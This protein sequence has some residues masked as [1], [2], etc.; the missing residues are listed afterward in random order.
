MKKIISIISLILISFCSNGQFLTDTVIV[1]GSTSSNSV[2]NVDL[3]QDGLKDLVVLA[4][5]HGIIYFYKNI[6]NSQFADKIAIVDFGRWF[7]G[8][9]LNFEDFDQD[10]DL[11]FCYYNISAS[12][13]FVFYRND[14]G[15]NF[16]NL[17]MALGSGFYP[18]SQNQTIAFKDL[19][20]DGLKDLILPGN[21]YAIYYR[22]LGNFQFQAVSGVTS[23]CDRVNIADFNNDGNK[24]VITSGSGYFKINLNDGS[25]VFSLSNEVMYGVSNGSSSYTDFAVYDY[26]QDGDNDVV[27]LNNGTVNTVKLYVNNGSGGFSAPS[28][29]YTTSSTI[30]RLFATNIDGDNI[31]DLV[32]LSHAA[33]ANCTVYFKSSSG[34]TFQNSGLTFHYLD[35]LLFDILDVNGDNLSELFSVRTNT[36]DYLQE[37]VT[38]SYSAPSNF[39][40][41]NVIDDFY[42]NANPDFLQIGDLNEDGLD[43]ILGFPVARIY[44]NTGDM[45]PVISYLSSQFANEYKL[46][47]LNQDGA[48]DIVGNQTNGLVYRLNNGSGTF[49]STVL[50]SSTDLS[51][52]G[53]RKFDIKDGDGDGDMD[54]YCTSEYSDLQVTRFTNNGNMNFV[55]SGNEYSEWST[56]L[57]L[58]IANNMI[59]S[60]DSSSSSN[61]I[62]V[63]VVSDNAS[64]ITC[65]FFGSPTAKL[66]FSNGISNSLSEIQ[67]M[68]I[69][70]DGLNDV[71]FVM[72][73]LLVW[74]RNQGDFTFAPPNA[75]NTNGNV[76]KMLILDTDNDGDLDIAVA[77]NSCNASRIGVIENLSFGN[78]ANEN[79]ILNNICFAGTIKLMAGDYQGDGDKDLFIHESNSDKISVLR[80]L[81]NNTSEISGTIFMDLDQNQ[82][83]DNND[84]G[85]S[86]IQVNSIGSGSIYANTNAIGDFN[87]NVFTGNH[88]ISPEINTNWSLTT[89]SSI[90]HVN[91][92]T[93]G[94]Q[95]DSLNFGIFPT[96]FFDSALVNLTGGF[97]R[98]NS[99]VNH[100]INTKNVGTNLQSGI[101]SLKMDT[102]TTFVYSSPIPD[103]IINSYCYWHY[104]NLNLN[105]FNRINIQLQFPPYTSMGNNITSIATSYIF[106]QS[107]IITDSITDTLS[108]VLVCGYDP[109]D[110]VNF[111]VGI[112]D[113]GFI[114]ND[115]EWL[116]YTIRFQNTGNDTVFNVRIVDQISPNLDISTFEL[117]GASSTVSI[118]YL[119]TSKLEFNFNNILLPDSSINFMGSQGFVV[120]KIKKN[121]N[122]SHGSEIKNKASIFFDMNPP[123]ITNT[124][125]NTIYECPFNYTVSDIDNIC[126]HSNIQANV[127]EYSYL[128]NY[129]WYLDSVELENAAILNWMSDT[130]GMFNLTLSVLNPLCPQYDT[131]FPVFIYPT[132]N[133]V[134]DTIS[135]CQGDS[136][137][138]NGNY[139]N[140]PN[141]YWEYLSTISGCDSIIGI[142]L[143]VNI[144]LSTILDNY[145]FDTICLQSN[146]IE[147]PIGYPPGGSY[148]GTG[149]VGNEFIPSIAGIGTFVTYYQF[150]DSNNCFTQDS[151]IITVENCL[152]LFEMNLSNY[153]IFPNPSNG[154]ISIKHNENSSYSL[155]ILDLLGQDYIEEFSIDQNIYEIDLSSFSK[156]IYYFEILDDVTNGKILYKIVLE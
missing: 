128:D 83:L 117:L 53:M 24:D 155:R 103:S 116:K 94:Q 44:S 46:A 129:I 115:Q 35:E 57:N 109:N 6:G 82:V 48:L 138:I 25:G 58:S 38:Y 125:L 130:S 42:F 49:G 2:L 37:F 29:L 119:P 96:Q 131:I 36:A 92:S 111:P 66:V 136:A 52:N 18:N 95:F 5:N 134:S 154:L 12:Q 141:V 145:I 114:T 139:E 69:D 40:V 99:I 98:C 77:Y 85:I 21:S 1:Q 97:P 102:S 152:G 72:S 156:G 51:Y 84:Y 142:A 91:V 133:F 64:K 89:D 147:L 144:P 45:I 71:V 15:L 137:F 43:D 76:E 104:D 59:L 60:K 81:L 34:S 153:S 110:K 120:F 8:T 86:N 65:S 108:Q 74:S 62:N 20:G 100:W 140:T 101:V 124:V 112:E 68:D 32:F 31:P 79:T 28:T 93:L 148:L 75:L 54:L 151:S 3:D 113:P 50:I 88:I 56:G 55:Y 41:N 26:D 132:Y 121:P 22:N 17:N 61:D 87:L 73:G 70:E 149:L 105:D 10:G 27:Y 118:N 135:I 126:N 16:T 78:F 19:D 33:G 143:N 80:N 23:T 47:D 107:G 90:Y 67:I 63:L 106:N 14:G 123:V 11:D 30:S 7:N 150:I 146:N 9:C 39:V 127:S 13:K 122:L 4:K